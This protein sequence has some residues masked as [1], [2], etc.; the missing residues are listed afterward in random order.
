MVHFRDRT[1]GDRGREGFLCSDLCGILAS[2]LGGSWFQLRVCILQIIGHDFHHVTSQV[3]SWYLYGSISFVVN[4][5]WCYIWLT[6]KLTSTR[7]SSYIYIYICYGTLK[8]NMPRFR[9]HR[10]Y[11]LSYCYGSF[12]SRY[13]RQNETSWWPVQAELSWGILGTQTPGP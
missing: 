3:A 6:C 12:N 2:S 11:L 7:T 4:A 9:I 1:E 13:S 10:E 8:Y 5:K